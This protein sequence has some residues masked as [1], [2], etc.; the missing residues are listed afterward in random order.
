M[1]VI[2]RTGTALK[3]LFGGRQEVQAEGG[4]VGELLTSLEVRDRLCD[5]SGKVRRHFNI[6]VNDGE[7]IRLLQSLNTP[8]KDGDTVTILSAI[9]GGTEIAGAE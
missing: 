2:V 9:A 4:T 7:D 5:S 1:P 3:S 6:H 8:V